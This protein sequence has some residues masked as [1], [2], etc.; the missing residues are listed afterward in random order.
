[1]R[2]VPQHRVTHLTTKSPHPSGVEKAK[3]PMQLN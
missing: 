3:S 2:S 1:M